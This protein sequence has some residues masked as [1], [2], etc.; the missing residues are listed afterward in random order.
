MSRCRPRQRRPDLVHQHG[1]AVHDPARRLVAAGMRRV[2]HQQPA[3]GV[4]FLRAGPHRLVI[5]ARDAHDVRAL[6]G[7]GAL[8][9]LAH[10]PRQ[11]HPAPGAGAP[12]TPRH[13]EPVVAVG[14]TA[15]GHVVDARR[16][17]ACS[18][19][20]DGDVISHSL[21]QQVHDCVCTAQRLEAAEAE[22]SALVLEPQFRD[23][24]RLREARQPMQRC[25]PVA[26]EARD[27][28]AGRCAALRQDHRVAIVVA[29]RHRRV[30]RVHVEEEGGSHGAAPAQRR[31]ASSG[32][33]SS[34]KRC[35]C[36]AFS[37]SGA[38]TFTT[39]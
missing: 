19:V 32:I 13:G 24:E 9:A 4:R 15:D 23:A 35:R 6:G 3:P 1:V 7:D 16:G 33:T 10:R 5:A 34:A 2:R 17:A 28:G 38:S 25:G 39:R 12:R 14:R 30:A 8:A 11:E 27:C 37:L 18:D 29:P 36:A 26:L 21:A 31:S 20:G 22:A